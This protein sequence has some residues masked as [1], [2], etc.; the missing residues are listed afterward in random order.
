ML[1]LVGIVEQSIKQEMA[2]VRGSIIYDGWT[3][4]GFHYNGVYA[5]Y[6][7]IFRVLRNGS[8]KHEETLAIT[9]LS[10]SPISITDEAQE[11]KQPQP[12]LEATKF[13]AANHVRH[14]EDA[15]SFYRFYVH[16]WV[17]CL[18]VDNASVNRWDA[19]LLEV[20]M[21]GCNRHQSN[22]EVQKMLREDTDLNKTVDSFHE[23]MSNCINL[24]RKRAIL[25]NLTT[26]G[27]VLN[28][29]TRWSSKYE[30]MKRF[31]QIRPS[32]IRVADSEGA[33]VTV[34][35]SLEFQNADITKEKQLNVINQCTLQLQKKGSTLS[36]CRYVLDTLIE[37]VAQ[38][39]Y[40]T[41][42]VLY[43]YKLSSARIESACSIA[44]NPQF[45]NGV[46]KYRE[47]NQTGR[48]MLKRRLRVLA[49]TDC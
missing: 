43:E 19:T 35:R 30:M 1:H 36:D 41:D 45:E 44:T 42:S 5:V 9:L 4:C 27:P 47:M 26:L 34:N 32:L 31:N 39:K 29:V 2:S 46:V 13:D 24:L 21:V 18:I 15:F 37:S 49:C 38:N 20:P 6:V 8:S 40:N 10:V 7:R 17:L 48:T 11:Q 28:N 12:V 22:L 16:E 3:D 14:L 33:T 23:T 25:R